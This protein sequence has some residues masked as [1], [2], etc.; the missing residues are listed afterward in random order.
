MIRRIWCENRISS[1]QDQISLHIYLITRIQ[2][3]PSTLENW[4]FVRIISSVCSDAKINFG[5]L[6]TR[7]LVPTKIA[8]RKL[9][10]RDLLFQINN[11]T[12]KIRGSN[13]LV[14]PFNPF[15]MFHLSTRRSTFYRTPVHVG[16][17]LKMWGT[18]KG[19][20][21][22]TLCCLCLYHHINAHAHI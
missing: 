22:I 3:S 15:H 18:A 21:P 13:H 12:S 6:V 2:L 8:S 10:S 9:R 20:S 5:I 17:L 7:H 16:F 1:V 11:K 14:Y 19:S 4:H